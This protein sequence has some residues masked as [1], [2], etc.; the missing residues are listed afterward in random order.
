MIVTAE[1]LTQTAYRPYGDVVSVRGD[2]T[3]KRANLGFADRYDFLARLES[4][5]P[6]ARPNLCV[7]HC[8]PQ[9]VAP[10]TSFAVKVL[11]RHAHST[12]VFVPMAGVERFLVIVCLGKDEPDPATLRAFLAT[13]AQGM[14]YHPGVWH[15]PLVA[16]DAPGEFACLVWED[17]S[18]GDAEVLPLAQ[19]TEI[20]VPLP[21]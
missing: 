14:T 13:G 1:P 5:R 9:L 18:A 16:L 10:A 4:R 17:G 8:R 15:H 2:V 6:G 12:Q 11:E 7:F 19:Q 3:P 20:A 21:R